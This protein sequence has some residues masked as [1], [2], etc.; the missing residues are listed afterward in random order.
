MPTD[1]NTNRIAG[2]EEL[3]RSQAGKAPAPVEQWDPPYC[4]DIGM[5]IRSDGVWL[6]QGSPIGR[7]PLVMTSNSHNER[8]LRAKHERAGHLDIAEKSGG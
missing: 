2:L 4:G 5:R 1:D 8:Y 6:Y 3:L 7:M